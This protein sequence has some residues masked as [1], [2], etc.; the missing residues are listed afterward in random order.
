MGGEGRGGEG[1]G[2]NTQEIIT[3]HFKTIRDKFHRPPTAVLLKCEK[4]AIFLVIL[5]Q[6][7][8]FK[9]ILRDRRADRQTDR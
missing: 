6:S 5:G 1:R 8:H 7:F 2:Q 3:F 4:N 9:Y